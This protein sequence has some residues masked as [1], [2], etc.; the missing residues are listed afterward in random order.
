MHDN[1]TITKFVPMKAKTLNPFEVV[2][3]KGIITIRV[4]TIMALDNDE[5]IDKGMLLLMA[6]NDLP[7]MTK[8]TA[9]AIKIK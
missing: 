4:A 5:A 9:E 1:K 6:E 2:L 7:N 3:K 8:W